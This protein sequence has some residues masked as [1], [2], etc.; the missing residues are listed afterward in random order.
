MQVMQAANVYTYILTE[1]EWYSGTDQQREAWTVEV[2]RKAAEAECRYASILVDP[3]PLMSMAPIG[4]RHAVWRYAAPTTDEEDFCAQLYGI[5]DVHR[6]TL[7]PVRMRALAL[8][9][10]GS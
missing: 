3:D 9:V 7:T 1:D 5:I 10:F 8:K 2:Q 4:R 6:T